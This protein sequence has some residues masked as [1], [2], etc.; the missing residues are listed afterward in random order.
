[1]PRTSKRAAWIVSA[2]LV[3]M[4]FAPLRADAYCV[5]KIDMIT[6]WG[7]YSPD[8]R[9][10]VRVSLSVDN[11]VLYTGRTPQDVARVLI[12]VI[13]RHNESTA[14]P[15]LYFAG[16]GNGPGITIESLSCEKSQS[17][18]PPPCS[19]GKAC[20]GVQ[21]HKLTKEPYGKVTLVPGECPGIN[22]DSWEADSY[23][24]IAQVM[25]HEIGHTLGMSHSNDS[26]DNCESFGK[27]HGGPAAGA[28]GVMQTVVPA[29]FAAFRSWRR[30]DLSALEYLYGAAAGTYE[31][32]W[33]DD[34]GY[35]HYPANKSAQ[36]LI[37]MPVSRSAAVSN[38]TS[39]PH[40]VLVT[41]A[42]DG[43]VIHRI[44]DDAGALTPN[45]G[46]EVVDPSQSG[47]TWATPA[48][49]LGVDGVDERILVAWAANEAS[50]STLVTLRTAVRPFDGLDWTFSNHP[51]EFR[52]TRLAAGFVPDPGVFIVATLTPATTELQVVFFDVDGG[53]LGPAFVLDGLYAFDVGAPLCEAARCLIPFSES[54]FGGPN[55]AVAELD[56]G[57]RAFSA[58]VASVEI[59]DPVDTFGRLALL[60]NTQE[61][62]AATGEHRFLLGNYPKLQPDDVPFSANLY[63]DW[64]LGIGLWDNQQR[65][66]FQP[67]AIICGNGIVQGSENCDDANAIAGDGCDGCVAD[68]IETGGTGDETGS[69]I[70]GVETGS[71]CECRARSPGREWLGPLALFGVWAFVRRM[72][73]RSP[74]RTAIG[75]ADADADRR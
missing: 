31:I 70:G 36:S 18:N 21:V 17:Q 6:L 71:D 39:S 16:F 58:S 63:A 1:M 5:T 72:R 59:L 25:L 48:V 33:W 60:D 65:R 40:Q 4:T 19:G 32:A 37:G 62:L 52:V 43:R 55:Y 61:L 67:R 9:I 7:T 28:N 23:V 57:P 22:E 38:R 53:S 49:A 12:E 3:S 15:K 8:L 45:L 20:G 2:M 44:M 35:P 51:D 41:T 42:P 11:T 54:V 29:S 13:A 68:G 73:V 27:V 14:I 74:S 56:V 47:V 75:P 50:D 10:P 34:A 26:K 66:L 30:D 64:P 46:D 69:D 24:D